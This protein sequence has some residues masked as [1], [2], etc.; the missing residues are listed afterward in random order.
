MLSVFESLG[1]RV[2]LASTIKDGLQ[3]ARTYTTGI[4]YILIDLDINGVN[5]RSVIIEI[6][7]EIAQH[8]KN[9]SKKIL[10]HSAKPIE[11]VIAGIGES[12]QIFF[13]VG[14]FLRK[15]ISLIEFAFYTEP[16]YYYLR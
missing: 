11:A 8:D 4:P 12:V 3:I 2:L 15:P 10:L 7:N 16:G 13:Y 14:G 6:L 9:L 5:I 1:Y